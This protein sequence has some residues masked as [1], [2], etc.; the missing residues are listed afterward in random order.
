LSNESFLTFQITYKVEQVGA[1][2]KDTIHAR[3][4]LVNFGVV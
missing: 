4:F 2:M 1:S 3:L